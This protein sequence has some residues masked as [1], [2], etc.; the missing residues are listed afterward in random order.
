MTNMHKPIH[1]VI[2]ADSFV[3]MCLIEKLRK[4][5]YKV[6]GTTRRKET[7][8]DDR[9]FFDFRDP[10]SLALP[11]GVEYVH[12][13]A[14]ATDYGRCA[15]IPECHMVNTVY[16]PRL[17]E[18]LLRCGL[19]VS[20]VSSNAIFGGDTPWPHEDAPHAPRFP[21]A[22][23]K[24]LAEQGV[25]RAARLCAAEHRLAIVR[26][27]KVLDASSSPLPAWLESWQ[28]GEP[29][30][31]F[32]DLT[33]APISRRFAASALARIAEKKVAGSL[34][35]SGAENITY[36]GFAHI[37]AKAMN[38]DHSLIVPTTAVEQG[39]DIPFKPRFSGLG[40]ARTTACTGLQPQ[41]PQA[42]VADILLSIN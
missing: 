33:F 36:V 21:Y 39:V 20:F 18:S 6:Y 31:P 34:H 8:A 14:A 27:T 26:L 37:L 12:V 11:S 16:T 9:I 25:C 32:A 38:I 7:L 35:V 28:R 22:L 15:A 41:T 4:L 2:G 30:R 42:V 29:V 10:A 24:D 1:L 23:Q 5:G 13:V 19:F 40:M 3:G 17:V